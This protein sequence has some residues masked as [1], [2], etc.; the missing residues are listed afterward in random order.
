LTSEINNKPGPKPMKDGTCCPG[1]GNSDI[2][3]KGRLEGHED[4]KGPVNDWA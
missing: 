1:G 4:I 3:G 2:Q